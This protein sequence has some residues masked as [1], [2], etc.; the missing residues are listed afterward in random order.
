MIVNQIGP[1]TKGWISPTGTIIGHRYNSHIRPYHLEI[2]FTRPK[3]FGVTEEWVLEEL[4]KTHFF[5][6]SRGQEFPRTKEDSD[7]FKE[8]MSDDILSGRFD[9]D[10]AL[11]EVMTSHKGFVKFYI[12]KTY[13]YFKF[14]KNTPTKVAHILSK[15]LQNVSLEKIFGQS[16]KFE[17]AVEWHGDGKYFKSASDLRSFIKRGGKPDNRTEKGKI[18]A[19]FRENKKP[20]KF[21]TFIKESKGGFEQIKNIAKR[22][23]LNDLAQSYRKIVKTLKTKPGH[24]IVLVKTKEDEEYSKRTGIGDGAEVKIQKISGN[25][26]GKTWTVKA[27]KREFTYEVIAIHRAGPQFVN[28]QQVEEAV[29]ATSAWNYV[30][31][32]EEHAEGF[33]EI[34]SFYV[35][36]Y[37]KNNGFKVRRVGKNVVIVANL[38]NVMYYNGWPTF[39]TMRQLIDSFTTEFD[40]MARNYKGTH[41]GK[42]R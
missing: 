25:S 37:A 4:M 12:G 42:K 36:R 27:G 17:F 32:S 30:F 9:I 6:Y 35:N 31:P 18:M 28:K 23:D 2:L 15:I 20:M 22:E 10:F 39:D 1:S 11:E 29:G 5:R 41:T 26:L 16:N 19:M 33:E 7:N 14:G 21:S 3:E 40:R 24:E 13:G 8:K 34:V 38:R